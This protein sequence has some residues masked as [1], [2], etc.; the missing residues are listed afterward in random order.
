M[1]YLHAKV[2]IFLVI[3][4]CHQNT[5]LLLEGSSSQVGRGMLQN[6]MHFRRGGLSEIDALYC[7]VLVAL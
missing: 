4:S 7:D 5:C 1:E 2:W 3:N 6:C